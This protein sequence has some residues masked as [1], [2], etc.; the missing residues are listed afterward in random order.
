MEK[1]LVKLNIQCFYKISKKLIYLYWGGR[2][3]V[4]RTDGWTP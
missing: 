1:I 4:G 3:D 2:D